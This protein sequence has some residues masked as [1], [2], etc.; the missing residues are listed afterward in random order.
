MAKLYAYGEAKPSAR[1]SSGMRSQGF[2]KREK[3]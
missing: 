3:R 1:E 2:L